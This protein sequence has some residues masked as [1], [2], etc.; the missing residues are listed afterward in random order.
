MNLHLPQSIVT[1]VELQQLAA[2]ANQ[3]ISVRECKPIIAIVQDVA[4][5]IYRLTKS[6]VTLT[7][8]Q[9]MNLLAS[10]PKGTCIVPEAMS[11]VGDIKKWSG[12]QVVS[13]ILPPNTNLR[14]PN[15][16]YD[17]EKPDDKENYVIVENGVLKQG[18][19]DKYIYQNRTK[20]LIHSIFNECGPEDTRHFL[21]NT[22]KIV[23]DWL[24]QAG[25]SVGISDIMI[26]PETDKEIK[27]TIHEMKVNVYD[28]IRDIHMNNFDNTSINSNNEFFEEEV[29]K[30]L[31]QTNNK[32]GK[33]AKA[34]INDLENR[35]IN[36]VNAGSKGSIINV[37]QMIA[38]LGQVNVDGK[39]IAY[40]FDDRTLPHYTKFDDGPESRG[41]VENSFIKGLTPQEFFFHAMGGREGL[42]DTAVKS[43]VGD[44]TIIIIENN[45]PKYVKIGDWIDSHMDS[46]IGK[47][48]KQLYP[49]DRNMEF[50]KLDKK[51]YIPT[52]DQ[53]GTTSWGELT[54]VTRHDPGERLYEF[55]TKSGRKVVVADSESM[56]IWNNKKNIFE[57][58]QS[59]DIKL[60]ERVP[61]TAKLAEP[62]I[63][64]QYIDMEEYFPKTE[65]IYGSECYKA[66]ELMKNASKGKKC[67]PN[68]WW[69]NNNGQS[70]IVPYKRSGYMTIALEREENNIQEGYVYINS[71]RAG[72]EIPDKFELN[73]ENGIFIGLYLAEGSTRNPRQV[74]I[75]NT[76]RDIK[77]FV[78]KW[79]DKYKIHNLEENYEAIDE[80]TNKKK[81]S[82]NIVGNSTLLA[83][84]LDTLVGHGA[85]NKFVPSIFF[86][87]PEEFITG[88][89][90]GYFAGDGSIAKNGIR[91][92]SISSRLIEGISMLCSRIGVFGKVSIKY[93]TKDQ[94]GKVKYI[95]P[96]YVLAINGQW[97]N[98]FA[99][100]VNCI[101]K[102]KDE[103][104]KKI[105]NTRQH[106]N[107]KEYNDIAMD[108]I[109][110]INILGV[111]K[112]PKLYDVTVPSTL[113]FQIA[114]GLQ[115]RDTSETGYINMGVE[116]RTGCEK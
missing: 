87:A 97:A 7:E 94:F 91:A 15:K 75:A 1:S 102:Y 53:H 3:I 104:L 83:T 64:K 2:V 101:L 20:G 54:A 9:V 63:I 111:E 37:S 84:F 18:I 81:I 79:F 69:K 5:G 90:N 50:L 41:F 31:N 8:K 66:T 99:K 59:K 23:C 76:D 115:V 39:R 71:K 48:E 78:I 85:K 96:E 17:E 49:E 60:Y 112:Y 62:P 114:N 47:T 32:V 100:K 107:F 92:S 108:K 25:F 70:F 26:D 6:S 56:L 113:N 21:D 34:K 110:K 55:T 80:I 82:E 95:N 40:G 30:I 16:L 68:N 73:H 28:K 12:R 105:K 4:L 109:I 57:K 43:V 22:Q 38:C 74:S 88:L 61:V 116:K 29:N 65:Y 10:N 27:K 98:M 106:C 72:C 45:I 52:C 51:V 46:Y 103:K 86:T 14:A 89:L 67:L 33:L 42:I 58:K 19:L 35:M 77:D 24:V 93:R 36:M 44:T 13:T 11:I